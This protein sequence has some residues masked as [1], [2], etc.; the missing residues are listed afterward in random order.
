MRNCE[1]VEDIKRYLYLEGLWWESVILL[2]RYYTTMPSLFDE[3]E[4][5]LGS[6]ASMA[7]R[8]QPD[9]LLKSLAEL[10]PSLEHP[11]GLILI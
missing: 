5:Q 1:S 3:D 10:I 7:Q 4:D 6:L 9:Y 8:R 11:G 2:S